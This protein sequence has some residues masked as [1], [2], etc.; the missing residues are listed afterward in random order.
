VSERSQSIRPGYRILGVD[1][2]TR[3]V[4]YAILELGVGSEL[5]VLLFSLVLLFCNLR[6]IVGKIGQ[7]LEYSIIFLFFDSAFFENILLTLLGQIPIVLNI[8]EVFHEGIISVLE[9]DY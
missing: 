4:G 5:I 1:P 9:F 7:L 8:L 2:G 3:V 6:H